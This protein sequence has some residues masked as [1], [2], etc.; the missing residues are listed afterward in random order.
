MRVAIIEI[1][2]PGHPPIAEAL[3]KIYSAIPG[4]HEIFIFCES[5]FK[6]SLEGS[7]LSNVQFILW[8]NGESASA[9]LS[10]TN[11]YNLDKGYVITLEASSKAS[12][13]ISKSFYNVRFHFPLTIFIHNIDMWFGAGFWKEALKLKNSKNLS[14]LIFNAKIYVAYKPLN[15]KIIQKTLLD[16]GKLAVLSRVVSEELQKYISQDKI[17]IVPF[18]VYDELPLN[19]SPAEN[20]RIRICIPGYVSAVRR[21]YYS[22]LKMLDECND[23]KDK[24]ELDFLGGV[25]VEE[26]GAEIAKLAQFYQEKGFHIRVENKKRVEIKEFDKRL[27]YADAIL[28]NLNLVLSQTNIYG[29]T[30]ESGIPFAMIKA[31][32]PG[33]L[34]VDYQVDAALES[35]V[36]R[37]RNYDEAL[38]I[39]RN[40]IEN[41]VQ[42]KRLKENARK[43]SEKYAPLEIYKQIEPVA[44]D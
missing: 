16:G 8:E 41:P 34:P 11:D 29:K 6:R 15:R 35:S 21:D 10:K 25:N 44:N 33:I 28:C 20:N 2:A 43:N 42:L 19:L 17:I 26:G 40:L 9:F 38:K 7:C 4:E 37:F 12:F 23:I 13:K 14:T 3:I 27:S 30:K 18:S 39:I 5:G 24:I 1:V 36:L 22:V 31:A 32:K